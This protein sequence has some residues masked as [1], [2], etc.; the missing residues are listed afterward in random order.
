[1]GFLKLWIVQRN[2]ERARYGDYLGFVCAAETEDE[3]RNMHPS[4]DDANWE[5][6]DVVSS[7]KTYHIPTCWVDRDNAGKLSV[8]MIGIAA[9]NVAGGVLFTETQGD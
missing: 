4:G 6:R 3:A 5:A 1:M 7:G 9:H 8:R 2:D